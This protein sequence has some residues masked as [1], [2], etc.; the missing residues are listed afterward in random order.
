[1]IDKIIKMYLSSELNEKTAFEFMRDL[2]ITQ[3]VL[4]RL[5]EMKHEKEAELE[6]FSIFYHTNNISSEIFS[7]KKYQKLIIEVNMIKDKIN[8]IID[9]NPSAVST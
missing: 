5:K 9:C 1:M 3:K 4:K 8:K 2:N 6:Q 7:M